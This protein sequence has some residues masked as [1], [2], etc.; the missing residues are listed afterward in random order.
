MP[1]YLIGAEPSAFGAGDLNNPQPYGL[2]SSE[3]TLLENKKKLHKV[4][5]KSNNQANEVE[6]LRQ[7]IDGLQTII[8]SISASSRENKLKLKELDKQNRDELESSS[9]YEKRILKSI[10]ETNELIVVNKLDIEKVNLSLVEMSK[11]IDT[12]NSTYVTKNEFNTLVNNVN[13]FKDLVAKE[14]KSNAKPKKSKLD[15]MSNGDVAT[16][17]KNYYDKKLYTEA[18]EY[19]KHLIKK[20]YKPARSHYMAGE[21]NYNRKNYAKAIAYFKESAKLYSKASYMPIL[22]LHTAISMDKTGDKENAKT[23]YNA[24]ISKYPDSSQAIEAKSK[25]DLIK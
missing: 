20:N 23:F 6:S 15:S 24:V 17:A 22:L 18:L 2:T 8:E 3:Q 11:L 19:Y 25:L 5:V 9:E 21:I 14:L 4:V 7:R 12:I 10:E 13:N 16:K 1:Y